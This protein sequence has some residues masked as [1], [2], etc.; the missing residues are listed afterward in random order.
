MNSDLGTK[1]AQSSNT[2]SDLAQNTPSRKKKIINSKT[3]HKRYT[4][5]DYKS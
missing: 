1:S 5:K 2:N 4:E 3:K